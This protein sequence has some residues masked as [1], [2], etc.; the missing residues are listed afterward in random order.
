MSS[1]FR[2]ASKEKIKV[3]F[4]NY[5]GRARFVIPVT[6]RPNSVAVNAN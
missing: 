2:P 5:A 6:K 1:G 3:R 4:T